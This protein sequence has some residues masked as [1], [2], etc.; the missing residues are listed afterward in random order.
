M[1][2]NRGLSEIRASYVH[3]NMVIIPLTLYCISFEQEYLDEVMRPR[4]CEFYERVDQR[5]RCF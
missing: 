1:C 3:L 2:L 5:S 4:A